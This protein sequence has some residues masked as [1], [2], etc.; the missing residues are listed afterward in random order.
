MK[1]NIFKYGL[2]SAGLLTVLFSLAFIFETA[3]SFSVSEIIGYISITIALSFIFFGIKTFRDEINK[4]LLSFLKAFKIGVLIS[5][6][7]A[8]TFG[9]INV[10]YSNFINPNFSTE[11][12]NDSIEKLRISLPEADFQE[13]LLE[14]ESQKA[15]FENPLFNFVIMGVTVIFMGVIISIISGLILKRKS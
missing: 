12:Y 9:V 1:K 15:L 8:F 11:Y 6:F 13:K 14:L 4:G 10:V 3:L 2:Y 7:P 5:L